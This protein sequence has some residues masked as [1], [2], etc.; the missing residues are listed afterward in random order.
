MST[1]SRLSVVLL[2]LALFA[3]R[4]AAHCSA[5]QFTAVASESVQLT[6]VQAL[7]VDAALPVDVVRCLCFSAARAWFCLWLTARASLLYLSLC[8]NTRRDLF[9]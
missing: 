7:F 5:S 3:S 8:L 4:A 1:M 6:P 2:A 9:H